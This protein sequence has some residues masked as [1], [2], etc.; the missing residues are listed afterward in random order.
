MRWHCFIYQRAS[1]IKAEQMKK[2]AYALIGLLLFTEYVNAQDK[3]S[4]I[5]NFSV[6]GY[7]QA[8][9]MGSGSGNEPDLY[10][11]G[12]NSTKLNADTRVSDEMVKY[13]E[14]KLKDFFGYAVTPADLNRPSTVPD[15]MGGR[16]W[17]M[18]TV[19]DKKAFKE[20][21]YD[22]VIEIQ[23]RIG[24]N[25][26]TGNNYKPFVEVFVKVKN[27]EGKTIFKKT[28][29]VKIEE[30]VP[31]RSI[32]LKNNSGISLD[33]SKSKGND[34]SEGITASQLLDWYKQALTN[35]LIK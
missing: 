25:G 26:K 33:F 16:L 12:D 30:K 34:D 35:A 17:V 15:Q 3:K 31:A 2:L 22:E 13:T 7:Q 11:I 14:E 4:G 5:T 8:M 18:E 19:T 23:C 1:T 29:K 10:F 21:G 28:E 24:S 9:N 32:E 6:N 27:K 20:L